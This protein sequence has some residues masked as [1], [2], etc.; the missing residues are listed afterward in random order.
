MAKSK[1]IFSV[2]VIKKISNIRKDDI[3]FSVVGSPEMKKEIN[4]VLQMANRRAQNLEKS[5]LVSPAY[6]VLVE[7][8]R[9]E[10]GFSKFSI[11]GK[12]I[13][14]K[15]QWGTVKDEYARAIEFLNNPTSMSNGAKQYIKHISK[16]Y[17]VPTEVAS[18]AI[19]L[20]TDLRV[21]TDGR[22][23]LNNYRSLIDEYLTDSKNAEQEMTQSAE[24]QAQAMEQQLQ[25][26][27]DKTY[28]DFREIEE[29]LLEDIANIFRIK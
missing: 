20:A 14:N 6:Q 21:Q 27:V 7:Q 13:T 3:Y 8:G 5:G 9:T 12:D 17:N 10:N 1:D 18:N 28:E 29:Q 4:R 25:Q 2:S 24:Q 26:E 15:A 11:S 19:R 23:Q 22:V 16:K